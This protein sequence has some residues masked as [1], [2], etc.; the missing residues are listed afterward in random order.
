MADGSASGSKILA[1]YRARTPRAAEL[2]RE[3]VTLLPSGIVHDS[4]RTGPYSIYGDRALGSHK[5]DIDGNE[6][7]DY[8]GGHGSLIL[9]H[10]HP[11]V[12]AAIQAQLGKGMHLAAANALEVEWARRIKQ[13]VP[14]AEKVRSESEARGVSLSSGFFTCPRAGRAATSRSKR[15]RP[16]MRDG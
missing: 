11:Q 5:W 13:M 8:Y 3:A 7:I 1:A 6:Y 9:G 4:R 14:S 10:Q 2:N 16:S 15:V 12:L